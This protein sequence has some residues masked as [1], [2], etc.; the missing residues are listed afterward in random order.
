MGPSLVPVRQRKLKW[1]HDESLDCGSSRE[2][3]QPS[4]TNETV[5]VKILEAF[6]CSDAYLYGNWR[7]HRVVTSSTGYQIWRTGRCKMTQVDSKAGTKIPRMFSKEGSPFI[8]ERGRAVT[9]FLVSAY[10]GFPGRALLHCKCFDSPC[11]M[12][13]CLK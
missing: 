2:K 8:V 11:G 5:Y 10:S 9:T 13:G 6:G 12:V 3:K 4:T 7:T 1:R